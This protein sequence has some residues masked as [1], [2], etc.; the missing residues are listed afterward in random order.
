MEIESCFK[1]GW[2]V[3]P[4]GLKG[5]VTVM[6]EDDAP[7]DFSSIESIFIEQNNRLVPYFIQAISF[8]GKKAYVKFDDINS[9]EDAGRISKQSLYI[10]KALRPTA[11]RGEFY[12]D[13]VIDFE[14]HDEEKGLLGKIREVMQAGPNRLLVVDYNNKEVLIPV[15]GPFITNIN[16]TKK[17][18]STSLPQGF[19]EI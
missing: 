14:V 13:E 12:D 15:N 9:A 2:I 5:E 10:Q 6:L 7:G 11:R 16:K 4:H 3:K 8:H 1:I 19:L 17:R 18:V